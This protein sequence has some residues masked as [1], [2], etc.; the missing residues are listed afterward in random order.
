MVSKGF[1][2]FSQGGPQGLLR[3]CGQTPFTE[4]KGIFKMKKL[5]E[6]VNLKDLGS[7]SEEDWEDF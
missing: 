6:K 4:K 7:H 2:L 3:L 5:S 1:G